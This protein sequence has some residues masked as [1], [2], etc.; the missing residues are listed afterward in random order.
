LVLLLLANKSDLPDSIS[1]VE[2]HRQM[3]LGSLSHRLRACH[4]Q[5]CSTVTGEGLDSAFTW[6]TAAIV[7]DQ[8]TMRRTVLGSAH[9]R[10]SRQKP[11]H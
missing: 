10:Q 7:G 6:Y 8:A 5:P 2:V 3:A 9:A 11:G 1:A 4:V